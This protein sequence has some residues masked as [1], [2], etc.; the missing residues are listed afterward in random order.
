MQGEKEVLAVVLP[1]V[2]GPAMETVG[3]LDESKMEGEGDTAGKG[4]PAKEEGTAD[5]GNR[6]KKLEAMML[7]TGIIAIAVAARYLH[8]L[9]QM[10]MK[11]G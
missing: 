10:P 5:P 4:N 6:Q 8:G 11:G 9:L 7:A 3:I 1:T 2:P